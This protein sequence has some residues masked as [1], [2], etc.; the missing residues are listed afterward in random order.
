M[1]SEP[2]LGLHP[3]PLGGYWLCDTA[4][5]LKDTIG[6]GS[7]NIAVIT[8]GIS[9]AN[10]AHEEQNWPHWVFQ[11]D[12]IDV[13]G[14]HG[15]VGLFSS[16]SFQGTTNIDQLL[17]CSN[18]RL[19]WCYLGENFPLSLEIFMILMLPSQSKMFT[20]G[21]TLTGATLGKK[22]LLVESVNYVVGHEGREK[23]NADIWDLANTLN[24]R[25]IPWVSSS[26]S[27]GIHD[28]LSME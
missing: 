21:N 18:E 13:I 4:K 12:A 11:C 24:F 7:H 9:G 14:I 5:H 8:G 27:K 28:E 3:I 17:W 10:G 16:T 19:R 23:R 1:Q 15:L 26:S 25:G 2:F 22:L 6:L 20:P